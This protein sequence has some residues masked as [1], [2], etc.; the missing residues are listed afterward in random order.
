MEPVMGF[1][2]MI[3]THDTY[4][5]TINGSLLAENLQAGKK[6]ISQGEYLT[7]GG[8]FVLAFAEPLLEVQRHQLSM[9]AADVRRSG[10][11]RRTTGA[12]PAS[13][14]SSDP[15]TGSRSSL[16]QPPLHPNPSAAT[17]KAG[18]DPLFGYDREERY[19][20]APDY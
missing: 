5:I 3:C 1:E 7:A 11:A 16:R 6:L 13:T 20:L 9:V 19:P 14:R 8:V 4:V 2:P 12:Q 15:S 18:R 17:L 10:F